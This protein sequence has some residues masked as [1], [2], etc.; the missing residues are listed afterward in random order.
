MGKREKGEHPEQG[1]ITGVRVKSYR[2]AGS[3][4]KS[5]MEV[6]IPLPSDKGKRGNGEGQHI[7]GKG[8]D[9]RLIG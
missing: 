1:W 8:K 2:C 6:T 7:S 9:S 3:P 4:E 5:G